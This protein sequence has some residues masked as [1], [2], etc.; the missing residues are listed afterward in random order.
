MRQMYAR[1]GSLAPFIKDGEV[2][3][4]DAMS[5]VLEIVRFVVS[6]NTLDTV[7]TT[8][9]THPDFE[10]VQ[11]RFVWALDSELIITV[12]QSGHHGISVLSAMGGQDSFAAEE[13]QLFHGRLT[14]AAK[15]SVKEIG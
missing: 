7:P 13:F 8:H 3:Y 1:R 2:D 14:V 10:S 4:D 5:G 11:V 6:G 15:A 9:I 12:R